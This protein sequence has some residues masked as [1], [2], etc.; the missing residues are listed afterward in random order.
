LAHFLIHSGVLS[1]YEK[2][3]NIYNCK[4]GKYTQLRPFFVLI[5]L[6]FLLNV[7][8]ETTKKER[9]QK[10]KDKMQIKKNFSRSNRTIGGRI[11]GNN[12]GRERESE[13]YI[14]RER[15]KTN[16]PQKS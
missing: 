9:T 2:E 13:R 15:V 10:N 6:S 4:L 1:K 12:A 14:A 3:K 8:R 11:R 16:R 7:K 5:P